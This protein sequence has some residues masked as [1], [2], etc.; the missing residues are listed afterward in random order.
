MNK[1]DLA[2]GR[3]RPGH[4]VDKSREELDYQQARNV[5][6]YSQTCK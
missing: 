5:G 2:D 4:G 3:C 6:T 1:Q